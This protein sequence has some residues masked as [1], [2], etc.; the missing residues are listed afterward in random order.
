MMTKIVIDRGDAV[1]IRAD[2]ADAK[3]RARRLRS[4]IAERMSSGQQQ[5]LTNA[6]R[7]LLLI[8]IAQELMIIP[9]GDV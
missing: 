9:V 1:V 3:A 6:E 5:L 8:A 7:D 4:V 2:T